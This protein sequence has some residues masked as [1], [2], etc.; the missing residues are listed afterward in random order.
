[1][2]KKDI[3]IGGKYV[4]RVSGNFVTVRVDAKRERFDHKGKCKEVYDVTNLKTGR[5][6]TFQSAAKFRWQATEISYQPAQQIAD[7]GGF[8][9]VR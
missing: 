8:E 7:C 2:K 4:A 3:T 6:L 9:L 5:K 1:M